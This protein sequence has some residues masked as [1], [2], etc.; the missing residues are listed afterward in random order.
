MAKNRS[1][2]AKRLK[3]A[4]RGRYARFSGETSKYAERIDRGR[5]KDVVKVGQEPNEDYVPTGRHVSILVGPVSLSK[6]VISTGR[7]PDNVRMA[8]YYNRVKSYDED[9][10]KRLGYTEPEFELLKRY[11]DL[12]NEHQVRRIVLVRNHTGRLDLMLLNN[13]FFFIDIDLKSKTIRRSKPYR[14]KE[15]AMLMLHLKNIRWIETISSV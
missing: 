13:Q 3:R 7:G 5:Y 14:D 6:Q 4:R 12:V 1:I 11:N 15:R 8:E 9:L 10:P 2:E